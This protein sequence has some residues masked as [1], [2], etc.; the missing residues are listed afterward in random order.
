MTNANTRLFA[1]V[2]GWILAFYGVRQRSWKGTIIAMAGVGL[3]EAAIAVGEH[4]L[5]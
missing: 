1:M 3:A 4:E 2:A 5:Q